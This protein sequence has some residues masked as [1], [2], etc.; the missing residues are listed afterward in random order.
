[1]RIS[2]DRY[3]RDRLCFDLALRMMGHGA[4]LVTVRNWTG[5]SIDRLRKLYRAYLAHQTSLTRSGRKRWPR[6]RVPRSAASFLQ[7][8]PLGFEATTLACLLRMLGLTAAD[9]G[10]HGLASNGEC[11]L[12]AEIFC[13]G[14]EIYLGLHSKPLL[15]FEHA[16]VLLKALIRRDE[17]KLECCGQCKRLYLTDAVRIDSANC[18]CSSRYLG[19]PRHRAKA[20]ADTPVRR[21]GP[22]EEPWR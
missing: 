14:Y 21:P 9:V 3:N 2:A 17:I 5:L 7:S 13:Q 20:A 1:M 19:L 18:G 11:L 16:F 22:P 6:G 10:I 8:T 15:S 12:Q 4:R